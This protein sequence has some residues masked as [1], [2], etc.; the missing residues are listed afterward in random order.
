MLLA[1]LL[2][3]AALL[4]ALP[5]DTRTQQLAE[6]YGATLTTLPP[7]AGQ[8]LVRRDGIVYFDGSQLSIDDGR[9]T[10]RLLG[11]PGPVFGSF[12]IEV[13]RE[14]LLFGEGSGG[15][16]WLVPTGAGTARHIATL[17][18]NFA[19]AL[20][21]PG[22]AILSA[23]TG[24]F[25]SPD[26]DLLMLD[27]VTGALDTIAVLPGASGPVVADGFGNVYYATASSTFPP[28]KGAV[29]ILR[30]APGQIATAAGP[31]HLNYQDA[32]VIARGLDAA[33]ALA[34]DDDQDLFVADWSKNQVLELSDV[35]SFA[36]R[37]AV[38]LDYAAAPVSGSALQFVPGDHHG[39][40]IQQFE[41]FQPAG[42]GT[43]HVHEVAF[44]TRSS[45]RHVVTARPLTG[46]DIA[47]P[48]PRARNFQV[49]VAGGPRQGSGLI[50]IGLSPG[51]HEL[52]F[53]LGFEAPVF[54][55]TA[56]L[57]P[58][59]LIPVAFDGKGE[60]RLMLYNPGFPQPLTIAAQGFAWSS[61]RLVGASS[62]PLALILR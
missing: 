39:H 14:L 46:T 24:G 10:R 47:Q 2:P 44:G 11:L 62:A 5:S 6:G 55:S 33:G 54:W 12:T 28:Q 9:S 7:T 29:E 58:L 26:N 27:L 49:V 38:L 60:G 30:F 34:L 56:L 22:K 42:A 43:L 31:G 13:E 59:L 20:Y 19:A 3:A 25:S 41:P 21:A 1:P 53:A 4:L 35:S 45:V 15:T 57:D 36:P 16:L 40:G 23:K 50:G 48:V 18:F 52:A 61:D 37:L 8:V 17:P 51:P 32:A